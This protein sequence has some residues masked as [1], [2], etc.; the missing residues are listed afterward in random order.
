MQKRLWYKAKTYG[1]GWYPVT[2][3]GWACTL[4]Y[5]VFVV[6]VAFDVDSKVH[7]V[8]ETL[9]RFFLLIVPATVVL[10]VIAYYTGEKP[11]WRWKGEIQSLRNKK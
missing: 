11:A 9:V 3:Q 8:P 10:C 5:V 1:L 7:T 6:L 4:G 2:W